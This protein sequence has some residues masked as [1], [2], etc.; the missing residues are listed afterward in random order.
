MKNVLVVTGLTYAD[1]SIANKEIIRQ[2]HEV[3]PNAVYDDLAELYPDYKID[4]AAEQAKLLAADVIVIQSPLFWYSPTSL[5]MRW[6]EEVFQH[7]WA[8]GSTGTQ[9]KGK[10]FI[11]A[12]TAG[13][14]NEAYAPGGD[15]GMTVEDIAKR[16][17]LMA[18]FCSLEYLGEVFTG[19]MV[20]LGTSDAENDARVAAAAKEHVAQIVK[21]LD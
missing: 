21:L 15:A 8:Y 2:M 10:G 3:L 13:S 7:G 18:S 20:N 12:F 9:L 16:F 6:F 4:I 1:G 5:I 19:G 17:K 11:V 14:S